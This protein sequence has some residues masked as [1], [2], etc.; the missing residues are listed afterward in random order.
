MCDQ[1]LYCTAVVTNHWLCLKYSKC[2]RISWDRPEKWNSA[3]CCPKE[4]TRFYDCESPRFSTEGR[5]KY[6]FHSPSLNVFHS[7]KP[8]I[9]PVGRDAWSHYE[10][11]LIAHAAIQ[12]SQLIHISI[13]PDTAQ[14]IAASSYLGFMVILAL[15][16]MHGKSDVFLLHLP[17]MW[18]TAGGYVRQILC[19]QRTLSMQRITSGPVYSKQTR[20]AVMW[21]GTVHGH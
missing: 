11:W 10:Y 18:L 14:A 5:T 4:T 19:A 1:Y 13:R 7:F 2:L 15:L 12:I 17:Y 6:I 16:C 21:G 3:I 9:V 8:A 20:F